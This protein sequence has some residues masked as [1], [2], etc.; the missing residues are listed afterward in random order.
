MQRVRLNLS[1]PEAKQAIQKLLCE[2]R[3]MRALLA[4]LFV[5]AGVQSVQAQNWPTRPVKLVVSQAACSPPD[6][7]CRIIAE[8]LSEA[9]GR[10]F[11]VENRPGS[12]NI[13]GAQAAARSAPDGYTFFFATAAALVT[14]PY[15]YKSLPYDPVRDFIP[16]AMVAKGP[17]MILS[18]PDLPVKNL[19]ELFDYDKANAGKLSLATDGSRNFS[20]ILASW[21]NKLAGANI[22]QVPYPNTQQ[23]A[24]DVVGGRVQVVI[25]AIPT[26]AS[27]IA[28]GQ[29]RPLAVSSLEPMPKF[30]NVPPMAQTFPGVELVGWFVFVAPAGTPAEVVQRLNRAMDRVL[31]EPAISN[32]LIDFGLYTQGADTPE[33]TGAFIRAQYET[34]GKVARDIGLEPQ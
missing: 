34:W 24:Q 8:R 15:T 27:F 10:P 7:A 26:A 3:L 9:F 30:E 23:G 6:I 31:K 17:F 18:H 28:N 11:F 4:F 33:A 22:T 5:V 12:G 32:R 21:L 20:G 19:K 29:L 25:L 14:N 16:V 1:A 2:E 13:I